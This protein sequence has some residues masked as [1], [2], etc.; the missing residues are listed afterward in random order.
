MTKRAG[1][2]DAQLFFII[3]EAFELF[4]ILQHS[5]DPNGEGDTAK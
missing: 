1:Y 2:R 3:D 5:W 4:I